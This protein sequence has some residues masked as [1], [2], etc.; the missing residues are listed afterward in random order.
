MDRISR[1]NGYYVGV[2]GKGWGPGV[3]TNYDGKPRQ[4][5]GKPFNK[6]TTTPPTSEFQKTIIQ[7]TLKTFE[8]GTKG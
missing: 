2:T 5:T 8:F 1:E 6:R 4:M 3:A 7:Q